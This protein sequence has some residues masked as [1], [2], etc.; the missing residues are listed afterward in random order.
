MKT[1]WRILVLIFWAFLSIGIAFRHAPELSS[2]GKPVAIDQVWRLYVA[3]VAVFW[4][5]CLFYWYRKDRK[6][7]PKSR[8]SIVY[9]WKPLEEFIT[10]FPGANFKDF[11]WSKKGGQLRRDLFRSDETPTQF[12]R[13]DSFYY[14][15]DRMGRLSRIVGSKISAAGVPPEKYFD[16]P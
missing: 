11:G 7:L 2:D 1:L 6:T 16:S 15:I 9:E 13:M 3:Y 4:G 8:K 5:I 12:Q 14:Y 10:Q